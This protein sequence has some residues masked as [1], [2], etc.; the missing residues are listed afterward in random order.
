MVKVLEKVGALNINV[1]FPNKAFVFGQYKKIDIIFN[2]QTETQVDRIYILSSKPL[3]TGFIIQEFG[4]IAA[5]STREDSIFIR[6]TMLK[7]SDEIDFL[8]LYTSKAYMR[9]FKLCYTLKVSKSFKTKCVIERIDGKKH[10]VC[11]DVFDNQDP[12]LYVERFFLD[13]I[14]MLSNIMQ[15]NKS[16]TISTNLQPDYLKKNNL[17]YFY[18]DEVDNAQ[19]QDI[20]RE[21]KQVFYDK[22]NQISVNDIKDNDIAKVIN[23]SKLSEKAFMGYLDQ[24]NRVIKVEF[25]NLSEN[26]RSKGFDHIKFF[27]R[28]FL[29]FEILWYYTNKTEMNRSM[30]FFSKENDDLLLGQHS[31]ISTPISSPS[32]KQ[33]KSKDPSSPMFTIRPIIDQTSID[34][35]F[36]QD[37]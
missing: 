34:H 3:N 23:T 22:T 32:Y 8:V 20:L 37:K 18:I 12:K 28:E 6:A 35:D 17:I 24:E 29:D 7:A 25:Q 36:K 33:K 15:L 26:L 2:N 10:L 30:R 4:P 19:N 14:V 31:I 9:A 27:C 5:K 11:I 16:K 13:S 1:I 21:N